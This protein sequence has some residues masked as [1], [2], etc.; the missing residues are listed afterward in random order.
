MTIRSFKPEKA[1][2]VHYSGLVSV[3]LFTES[4]KKICWKTGERLS[5]CDEHH[6]RL[7]EETKY[8]N[9]IN[10]EHSIHFHNQGGATFTHVESLKPLNK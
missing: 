1:L 2:A 5:V 6:E 9:K 8:T 10:Q 7:L 4:C 3:H